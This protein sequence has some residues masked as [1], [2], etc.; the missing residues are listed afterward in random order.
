MGAAGSGVFLSTN[1]G[2]SWSLANSGLVAHPNVSSLA[3][4][5]ANLYAGTNNDGVFLSTNNGTSWSPINLGLDL[6]I[7]SLAVSGSN[8][9]AGC[10]VKFGAS[11]SLSTDNGMSWSIVGSGIT[12]VA[13]GST[14]LAATWDCELMGCWGD[15]VSFHRRGHK[16]DRHQLWVWAAGVGTTLF[17][18]SAILIFL[19]VPIGAVF[20]FSTDNGLSWTQVLNRYHNCCIPLCW[21]RVSLLQEQRMAS[22][23]LRTRYRLD[24]RKCRSDRYSHILCC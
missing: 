3:V 19:Q 9:L 16:L 17:S 5:E 8:L 23:V 4:R 6:N 20:F 21:W 12:V 10:L 7:I 2:V 18:L 11:M 1:N 22:F 14:V 13:S 24:I 15:I